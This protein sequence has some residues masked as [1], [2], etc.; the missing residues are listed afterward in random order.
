MHR[1]R[2]VFLAGLGSAFPQANGVENRKALQKA[3]DQTGTIAVSRPGTYK[4][5]PDSQRLTPL[6]ANHPA[7][8]AQRLY[9]DIP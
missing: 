9:I 8:F 6:R 3:V 4:L 1:G 5:S 2:D 7:G